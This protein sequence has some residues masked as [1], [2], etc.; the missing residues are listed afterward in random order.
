MGKGGKGSEA[1]VVVRLSLQDGEEA[2]VVP[3]CQGL[4]LSELTYRNRVTNLCSITRVTIFTMTLRCVE[5]DSAF[6]V[7][8]T[9]S[10]AWVNALCV[11]AG[12][13]AIAV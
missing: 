1:G 9:A 11:F 2:Q 5:E 12:F 3:C 6:S 13:A 10:N 7:Q 8:T 4:K